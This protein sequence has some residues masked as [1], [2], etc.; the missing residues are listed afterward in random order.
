[1]GNPYLRRTKA[2]N[3]DFRY[4]WYHKST[5]QLLLGVFYKYI[6]D[7]IEY[8]FVSAGSSK[9]NLQPQNFGNARNYGFE[10]VFIKYFRNFGI[11]ANY[12]YTR[13]QITTTKQN[14]YLDAEKQI[15]TDKVTQTRPLQGQAD[16]I[17]NL[18]LM[19]KDQK[20]GLDLQLSGVY[21]GHL[22]T[23][24]SPYYGLDYW[25]YPITTLDFSFEQKL[26]RKINLS[27]YGKA[28]N[29]LNSKAITRFLAFP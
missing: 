8:A 11:T 25:A 27:L 13:S 22:I 1:M 28:K 3:L 6:T 20:I 29:L 24:V 15:Q 16:N 12:T 18:S 21:T 10:M 9:L 26:S 23:Q 19:Y 14:Y 2:D 17:A 7:P 5:D 4:E